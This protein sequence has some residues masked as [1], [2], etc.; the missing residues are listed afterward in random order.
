ME[1]APFELHQR[2]KQLV[3]LQDLFSLAEPFLVGFDRN[4]H[5]RNSVVLMLSKA[6]PANAPPGEVP[7]RTRLF[8]RGKKQLQRR[9][10][11]ARKNP[12]FTI[13]PPLPAAA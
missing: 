6:G 3:D 9:N 2:S 1:I 5:L 12:V 11:R 10:F 8:R 4:C 13:G 7:P